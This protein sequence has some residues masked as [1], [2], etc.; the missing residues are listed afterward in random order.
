MP[1]YAFGETDEDVNRKVFTAVSS[2]LVP[3]VCVGETLEEREAGREQEVVSRQL[4]EALK[5]I[6]EIRPTDI[7]VAYEPVWAIGTGKN[8]QP[9]QAQEVHEAIRNQLAAQYG[10]D[11]SEATR[12]VYGGSV[13]PDNS[14]SLM[15]QPDVDG[16]LV[17]GASLDADSFYAI[18]NAIK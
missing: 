3:I 14:P 12:I 15:A 6:E 10:S 1:A 13:T 5:G 9:E 2:D 4:S 8:A 7:V 11:I 17:G 18:I 16:A